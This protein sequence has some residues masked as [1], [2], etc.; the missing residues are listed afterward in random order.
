VAG[1][2]WYVGMYNWVDIVT[3]LSLVE[4]RDLRE[5]VRQAHG[6]IGKIAQKDSLISKLF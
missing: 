6:L 4:Y 1:V 3:A 2:E 5:L